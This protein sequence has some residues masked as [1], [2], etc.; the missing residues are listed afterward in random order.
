[1]GRERPGIEARGKAIRITFSY[2]GQR[3]RETIRIPPTQRNLKYA[4]LKR[5]EILYQI[6]IGAFTYGDHFPNSA[7]ARLGRRRSD[8][9]VKQGTE[10]WM[11]GRVLKRS[12]RRGYEV[13]IRNYILPQLGN[14]ALRS[15]LPSELDQW[16]AKLAST[17]KPKTVNNALIILRGA[18]ELAHA[19]GVL[20]NNPAARMRNVV[21][22]RKSEA[23]PF[24]PAELKAIF[25]RLSGQ[26]LNVFEFWV[27]T[28]LRSGEIRALD[29]KSID[30]VNKQAHV[31]AST[32]LSEETDTKTHS[33]RFVKLG[34]R[35]VAVLER[36]KAHSLLAGGKVF[37]DGAEPWTA[38]HLLHRRWT[39]ACKLGG[40]RHRPPKQLRHTYASSALSAGE[41]PYFVME[42]LGHS[43]FQ[44]M[45]RHYGKW[46]KSVNPTAGDAFEKVA[47][48][49]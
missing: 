15:I 41:N 49:F 24:D 6:Q 34:T 10:S 22:S 13:S 5:A 20:K 37:L 12:T 11:K 29:W 21:V 30:W 46:M 36:Q 44:M 19:D 3:C 14:R 18:F 9:T 7:N 8:L 2:L 4:E 17:Q 1:M 33:E 43:S 32:T 40:V 27:L 39:R 31:H 42:Q 25:T 47:A 45:E 16:R 48:R 28:G 23:D 26:E 38:D 35:A